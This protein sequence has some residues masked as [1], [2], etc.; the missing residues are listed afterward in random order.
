MT[1]A[2]QLQ[3]LSSTKPTIYDPDSISDDE[4]AAVVVPK[5][6]DENEEKLEYPFPRKKSVLLSDVDQRYQGKQISRHLA[7]ENDNEDE[8]EQE[9]EPSDETN[10][11]ESQSDDE[12]VIINEEEVEEEEDVDIDG[13]VVKLPA[14]INQQ[15]KH[16]L[17]NGDSRTKT[18]DLKKA[19]AVR[20][21]ISLWD[22]FLE[23]RIK[24]QK[25][26]ITCN[27]LPQNSTQMNDEKLSQ[28]MLENSTLLRKN[29]ALL[30]AITQ[31]LS[32]Q[33]SLKRQRES[34]NEDIDDEQ[35]TTKMFKTISKRLR[36]DVDCVDDEI[37]QVYDSFIPYRDDTVQ[38]WYDKTHTFTKKNKS[39]IID[40]SPLTQIKQIMS[41]PDRLIKRTKT[42]R[43]DYDFVS[44]NNNNESNDEIFDDGDFYHQLLREFIER[45][46]ASITDPLQI[47]R[48][49]AQLRKLRSKSKKKVDTKA[50]KG[51]KIR[52]N[53]H[54]KLVNFMAPTDR[55]TFTEDAKND[56]FSSLFGKH[57]TEAKSMWTDNGIR[58]I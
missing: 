6:A 4:T 37:K 26:C 32:G 30:L 49:W 56:L 3:E 10:E 43:I 58:L 13:T 53:V 7:F 31:K 17:E 35:S 48:H 45:K 1:L 42:C 28:V 5:F 34:E 27:C 47:S 22:S 25:A 18:T 19:E 12:D 38:K 51:R 15:Q 44:S 36:R 2:K 16:H 40:Q 20:R 9:D 50:S 14:D 46:T 33:S 57:E 52:Y 55:S 8:I 24:L 11:E 39:G 21:Q 54:K 23:L 29:I 41:I